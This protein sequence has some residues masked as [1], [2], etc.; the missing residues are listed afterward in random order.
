MTCIQHTEVSSITAV[1]YI[2]YM[3][4]RKLLIVSSPVGKH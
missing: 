3:Y 4:I 2:K 1:G